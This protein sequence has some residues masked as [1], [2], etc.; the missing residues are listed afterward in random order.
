MSA[1]SVDSDQYV[2]ASVDTAHL[3]LPWTS[4]VPVI[5]Q[6]ITLTHTNT[7]KYMQIG[8]LGIASRLMTFTN[9]GTG[10]SVVLLKLPLNFANS[11]LLVGGTFFFN[12]HGSS[13]DYIGTVSGTSLANDTVHFLVA[14]NTAITD[15]ELG[16]V[17]DSDGS[18]EITSGSEL[19]FMISFAV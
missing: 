9:T 17:L 8:N 15:A 5:T 12:H 11:I 2:D 18:R 6:G 16:N 13:V 19:R 10:G 3:N 4:W 1:N 14:H 7:T